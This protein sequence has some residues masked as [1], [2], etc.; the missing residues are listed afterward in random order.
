M[1]L[2][3][4]LTLAAA[5]ALALTG[6]GAA[7]AAATGHGHAK[8]STHKSSTSV[9]TLFGKSG[10]AGGRGFGGP[11]RGLA[12]DFATVTAYLGITTAQLRTDLKSGKTLAQIADATS[13]KSSAGLIAALVAAEKTEIA[14]AVTA[15]KLTQTQADQVTANLPARVTNMVNGT[16]PAGP[17]P[18]FGG[19]GIGP[20]GDFA[21]VTAYLGITTTEL[22]TDLKSGKTLA[23]I[24]DA[25]SGKS[26][27][28]LIAALVTAEKTEIAVA[29]TAGKL[30]QAQADQITANLQTRVTDLVN[31]TRP[32]GGR[33]YGGPHG[34]W[35]GA[36]PSGTTTTGFWGGSNA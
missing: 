18:G 36:P 4:K 30:T 31:G 34:G 20:G 7:V 23:Q 28:G 32:A 8:T 22:Q 26:S 9:S 6:A 33:P 29:V 11:G 35:G 5:G 10:H 3:R 24:A 25:T 2:K 17:A 14:A 15:G 16:R 1:L 21:A 13:G 27:A 12:N 19:P